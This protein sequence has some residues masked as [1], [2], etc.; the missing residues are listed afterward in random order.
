MHVVAREAVTLAHFCVAHPTHGALAVRAVLAHPEALVLVVVFRVR[1]ELDDRGIVVRPIPERNRLVQ[2]HVVLACRPEGGRLVLV[3]PHDS[4]HHFAVRRSRRRLEVF[5][6]GGR[7]AIYLIV[8]EEDVVAGPQTR[9]D[10]AL[11]VHSVR[12]AIRVRS[13]GDGQL[14]DVR[15]ER[16]PSERS[17]NLQGILGQRGG[18]GRR[19]GGEARVHDD[20]CISV[21]G[22][23]VVAP[24][25]GA[26]HEVEGGGGRLGVRV[27]HD[28]VVFPRF[29]GAVRD[30]LYRVHELGRRRRSPAEV[31]N[32]VVPVVHLLVVR[33]VLVRRA[34][35]ALQLRFR[36]RGHADL[37]QQETCD[38][39]AGAAYR[40][41]QQKRICVVG[42]RDH[43]GR[44]RAGRALAGEEVRALP[45][46][47]LVRNDI[48]LARAELREGQRIIREDI[49]DDLGSHH[50]VREA[51]ELQGELHLQ[52]LAGGRSIRRAGRDGR[53]GGQGATAHGD[54]GARGAVVAHD[55]RGVEHLVGQL[56][57]GGH[58]V[59]TR[60]R[61]GRVAVHVDGLGVACA[62]AG[63]GVC[64]D[65]EAPGR[66]AL[67]VHAGVERVHAD[68][69]LLVAAVWAGPA[70]VAGAAHGGV[71]VPQAVGVAVVVFL[72]LGDA[73]AYPVAIAV[74]GTRS[75]LARGALIAREA[76]ALAGL[77]IAQTLVGALRVVVARVVD[78]V[79]RVRV[80]GAGLR[81]HQGREQR[82]LLRG[83]DGINVRRARGYHIGASIADALHRA[84]SVQ[85]S[86]GTVHVGHA[87]LARPLRAIRGLP[88]GEAA[89]RILASAGTMPTARIG[90]LRLA[91]AKQA[92]AHDETGH[93]SPHTSV[94][95][96]AA[97]GAA[98]ANAAAADAAA[99]GAAAANAAAADADA[100][101]AAGRSEHCLNCHVDARGQ[102]STT[103]ATASTAFHPPGLKARTRFAGFPESRETSRS[104]QTKPLA[105]RHGPP[106]AGQPLRTDI[107]T[108]DIPFHCFRISHRF[109]RPLLWTSDSGFGAMDGASGAA[110]ILGS[111]IARSG[112]RDLFGS[113]TQDLWF[114]DAGLQAGGETETEISAPTQ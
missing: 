44:S 4:V 26:A 108:S 40:P 21:G 101:A 99:A 32:A 31:V 39:R 64:R 47:V 110:G 23:D 20:A 105:A 95:A 36:A 85:V 73:L 14:D 30:K 98:A 78:A 17:G 68:G 104:H 79:V 29:A 46:V 27:V 10:V 92:E 65:D 81:A 91:V 102:S 45:R 80:L 60:V 28:D 74:V 87:E 100:D 103:N 19:R 50:L 53:A 111:A 18:G 9:A 15:A 56:P 61:A 52:E 96:A 48:R 71:L 16:R 77:P 1:R 37:G 62:A 89:A 84:I 57:D 13:L 2:D 83:A 22:E 112:T 43:H 113:G 90:A 11:V 54:D 58:D 94:S 114:R 3:E 106:P 86:L 41:S 49:G 70:C 67:G 97:A 33:R 109:K 34:E 75:S 88:V 63:V 5:H 12:V 35:A 82:E 72:Q 25:H 76:H 55:G 42:H 6:L 24:R 51:G 69:A 107:R 93:H 38:G 66:V 8:D 59:G 7:L